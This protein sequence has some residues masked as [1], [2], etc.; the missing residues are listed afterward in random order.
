MLDI[1]GQLVFLE[2]NTSAVNM[3]S[4][5]SIHVPLFDSDYDLGNNSFR[6][7]YS[8]CRTKSIS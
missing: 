6:H 8:N 4:V 2:H 5:S 7:E 3:R 1:E